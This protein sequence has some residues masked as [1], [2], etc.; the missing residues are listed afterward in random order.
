MLV[1]SKM[2]IPCSVVL[3]FVPPASAESD[4]LEFRLRAFKPRGQS[5]GLLVRITCYCD[6][7]D[8]HRIRVDCERNGA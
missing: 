7:L 6:V 1:R 8:E 3:P 5:V 2:L 4:F